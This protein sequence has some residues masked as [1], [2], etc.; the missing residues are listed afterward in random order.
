MAKGPHLAIELWPEGA[1]VVVVS[2]FEKS[3]SIGRHGAGLRVTLR[4]VGVAGG[5]YGGRCRNKLPPLQRRP[6]GV[7][8]DVHLGGF[9]CRVVVSISLPAGTSS[10]ILVL[11]GK[12]EC[13][14][15]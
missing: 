9:T 13:R 1:A 5:R 10:K 3:D 15:A 12:S 2:P 6:I 11:V 4:A 14:M 8:G 7:G